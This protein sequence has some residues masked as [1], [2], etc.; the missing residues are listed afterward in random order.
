[1]KIFSIPPSYKEKIAKIEKIDAILALII[2]F[3]YFVAMAIL[4]LIA[5]KVSYWQITFIGAVTNLFFSIAVLFILKLKKQSIS[6]I[7]LKGGNIKLSLILG[8]VLSA[9]LFFCNCLSNIWFQ[10]QKFI[11][12]LDILIFLAYFFTVAFAEEVLFR[13][14]LQTTLYAFTKN[15]ALDVLISGILF[16]LMHFPFRMVAYNKS[17]FDLLFDYSYML[18][19]FITHLI[20]SFIKIKSDNLLGSILPH[21]VS[22][23]A[24]NIVTHG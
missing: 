11:A 24:Y 19:L 4:G 14:F 16:V 20:L 1:M 15:I 22:N 13:G 2:I 7:G 10:N 23:F 5:N 17:F 8:G 18:N 6:L 12:I 21:W 3:A 9:I